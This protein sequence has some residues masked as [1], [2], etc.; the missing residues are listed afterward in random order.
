[1]RYYLALDGTSD[2]TNQKRCEVG[3]KIGQ[4]TAIC[5]LPESLDPDDLA[6]EQLA[7][8]KSDARPVLTDWLEMIQSMPAEKKQVQRKRLAE[9][10][11]GWDQADPGGAGDRRA[12][13]CA[14]LGLTQSEYF[15]WMGV[16]TAPEPQNAPESRPEQPKPLSPAPV[17]LDKREI[18][19]N[20][21]WVPNPKAGEK[22]QPD[23]LPKAL[24]VD[25]IVVKLL[26]I[27][28]K[29]PCRVQAPS[30]DKPLLFADKGDAGVWHAD[31]EECHA[32]ASRLIADRSKLTRITW[33]QSSEKCKSWL[34][35]RVR[36][37]F[38]DR[39]DFQGSNFVTVTDLYHSL[40]Q[41]EDVGEYVSVEIRPHFPAMKQHYYAWSWTKKPSNAPKWGCGSYLQ[42]LLE[43]FDNCKDASSRAVL[44]AA[45]LTPAWGGPYGKR[46]AFVVTAPDRGYGKSTIAE[47][48]AKIWA[49][50]MAINWESRNDEELLHRLLSPTALT[51]R[52][53]IIDN[54]KGTLNSGLIEAL[55][56]E[57][58]ISGKRMYSGE[59]S[60]PNTM[61][62]FITA[63]GVRLSRD[64]AARSFFVELKKPDY[65]SGWDERLAEFVYDNLVDLVAD[66]DAVLTAP[67]TMECKKLDRWALWEKEVLTRAC[68]FVGD[69]TPDE[70]M[71]LSSG[72]RN[73]CDDDLEEARMLVQ[74]I[75]E[76][77][78]LEE[79][80][81]IITVIGAN[82]RRVQWESVPKTPLFIPSATMT[83]YFKKILGKDKLSSKQ[84]NHIMS[85]HLGAG[86]MKEI[87]F[88]RT[89]AANGYEVT[90]EAVN[91]FLKVIEAD[92]ERQYREQ[93]EAVSA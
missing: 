41:V 77:E 10:L 85:E 76:R 40:G 84:V 23:E 32:K 44:A 71:E 12:E 21:E 82:K 47:M 89:A 79:R 86:R 42:T 27:T 25:Q 64:I 11:K 57:T 70:V 8:I 34:H 67:L 19:S 37:Q 45:V 1:V 90:V 28:G 66:I 68:Q 87:N 61:T 38:K 9:C 3:A 18:L 51:K 7:Q 22:G 33:M 15:A 91:R 72:L 5:V 74:G 30:A 49:G 39:A 26:S 65:R 50:H 35:Q 29:W 17:G 80:N 48:I 56:T 60:R 62:Y 46:P 16:Q 54:V 92:I 6:G 53:A 69:I 75:L 36:L 2:V 24:T 93:T 63:N 13:V 4:H 20:F 43:F 52:I 78:I 59:A 31:D 88:K 14:A 81:L 55:I 73:E 58:E 83:E